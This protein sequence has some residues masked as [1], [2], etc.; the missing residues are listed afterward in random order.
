MVWEKNLKKIEMHNLEHS[1][2]K[3]SY[4]L[5]MNHFGDMVRH[6]HTGAPTDRSVTGSCVQITSFWFQFL[7]RLPLRRE[8]KLL[9]CSHCDDCVRSR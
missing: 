3:H 2:G 7:K 8:L 5:G 9:A 6:V 4:S 1:L